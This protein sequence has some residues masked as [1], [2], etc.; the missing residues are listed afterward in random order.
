[1]LW[2]SPQALTIRKRGH[3]MGHHPQTAEAIATSEA[4]RPRLPGQIA[5]IIGNEGCERFSFYGMR[6]IL[7]HYLRHSAL[8]FAANTKD[9]VP[10]SWPNNCNFHA[11]YTSAAISNATTVTL[12][13]S[14]SGSSSSNS[15]VWNHTT[16]G[17]ASGDQAEAMYSVVDGKSSGQ[18]CCQCATHKSG[19]PRRS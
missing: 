11:Y 10:N 17:I 19:Q 9:C 16:R 7:T 15:T 8:L 3:E 4:T 18:W 2:A 5:Y 13:A 12:T 6:N 14:Y 1:M